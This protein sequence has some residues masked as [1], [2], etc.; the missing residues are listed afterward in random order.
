MMQDIAMYLQDI[1]ENSIRAESSNIDIL[2]EENE[3]NNT[4]LFS[5]TDNGKG[6]EQSTIDHVTSPFFSTRTT[7]KVGLGIP[8]LNDLAKGCNGELT[9]TSKVSIGTTIKVKVEL[10]HIDLPPLG[11]LGEVM[12]TLIQYAPGIHYNM[13]YRLN[14]QEFEFDSFTIKEML[15]DVAIDDPTILLWIKDYIDEH[16]KQT[17]EV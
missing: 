11:K 3:S 13:I 16:I 8:L 4:F 10:N 14:S 7:R 15:S 6:M 17:R 2:I 9:I 5:I 12:M 1:T